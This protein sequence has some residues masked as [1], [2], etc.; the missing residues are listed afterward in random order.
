MF[1]ALTASLGTS[2]VS[3]AALPAAQFVAGPGSAGG[4]YLTPVVVTFKGQGA[5]FDN[6][7]LTRHDVVSS[8]GLFRSSY[9]GFGG[10]K[11]IAG[12]KYLPRGT[13]FFYCSLHQS[14][15]KGRLIVR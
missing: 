3:N 11:A 8:A 6:F 9:A 7:D 5:I 12:V 14:T 1:A 2:S 10:T 4:G 13:Y 15:M